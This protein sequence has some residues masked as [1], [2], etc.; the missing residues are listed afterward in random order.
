[1]ISKV[2]II[3]NGF[4]KYHGLPS[5]YSDFRIWLETNNP[6]LL[7]DLTEVWDNR[8]DMLWS[9]FEQA[10]G[11]LD[12]YNFIHRYKDYNIKK[13]LTEAQIFYKE[14]PELPPNLYFH[15]LQE[16]LRP[17]VKSIQLAFQSWITDLNSTL[18]NIKPKL[19][20]DKSASYI[21]FN[22]TD[23]LESV[24]GI[25]LLN[26]LHIHGRASNG[27][28]LIFGH[29]KT[30]HQIEYEIEQMHLGASWRDI[31]D[32]ALE[33]SALWK[34]VDY[35]LF[36]VTPAFK[37]LENVNEINI[38]GYSFNNIDSEYMNELWERTYKNKP[39]WN[40]SIHSD[41]DKER[42]IQF[43]SQHIIPNE[44]YELITL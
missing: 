1:M 21:T 38:Y 34:N 39:H 2:Y 41:N 23:T 9:D 4:D 22:Y 11:N 18:S 37:L 5:S 12:F 16:K 8:A 28:N 13:R 31:N 15:P 20:L 7:K 43:L 14:H 33:L 3:G 24:Y 19:A 42:V 44:R 36:T 25:D 27:D 32:I 6:D 40:I 17:L 35:N 10:L 26:I 30:S 29:R